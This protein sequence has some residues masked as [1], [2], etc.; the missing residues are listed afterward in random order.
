MRKRSNFEQL[1]DIIDADVQHR[2]MDAAGI[3]TSYLEAG[4]GPPVVLLHGAGG[5]AVTWYKAI[6][7]LS[8]HFRVIAFDRPGYGESEKPSASYDKAFNT[9][10]LRQAIEELKLKRFS[11][12]GN[13]EGGSAGIHFSLSYPELLEKLILVG[14]AGLGDDWN[15]AIIFKM[16]L[17]KLFPSS[18]WGELLGRNVMQNPDDAHPAWH[19]YSTDVL[20]SKGGRRAFFQGRGRAVITYSDEELRAVSTPT[21]LIWG[22]DEAFFPVVHG[23][24][25]A[26]LIPGARLEVISGAG[27][28]PFMEKPELFCQLVE[29]FLSPV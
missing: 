14:S 12:I 22:E 3:K 6:G 5:G 4:S 17:Y 15:K 21:L 10:W 28:L 1:L 13:S 20:K 8:R 24:R 19:D 9:N 27:H 2:Y 25:A 29:G 11:L 7:P 18:I 26:R 16:A 23:E